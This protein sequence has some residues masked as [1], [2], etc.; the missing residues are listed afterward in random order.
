[1]NILEIYKKYQIM[2]QLAEHQLT[3][4]G[5]AEIICKNT[6][7]IRPASR[8]LSPR[9]RRALNPRIARILWRRVCCMIWGIL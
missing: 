9:G 2:P 3:V 1:M 5:V 6:T 4:A 7:L 8:N